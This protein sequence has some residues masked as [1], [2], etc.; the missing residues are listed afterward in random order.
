MALANE[1]SKPRTQVRWRFV[2]TCSVVIGFALGLVVYFGM[3]PI[4]RYLT[5]SVG[6]HG[7]LH[8]YTTAVRFKM[9]LMAAGAGAVSMLMA[10][11]NEALSSFLR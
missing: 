3:D 2:L 7:R 10:G 8:P 9:A 1:R 6:G 4:A 5:Q 11:V